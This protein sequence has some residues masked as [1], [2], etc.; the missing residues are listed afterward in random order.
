[1]ININFHFFLNHAIPN[2]KLKEIT[3][4]YPNL[5]QVNLTN[6]DFIKDSAL[7]HIARKST[8]LEYLNLNRCKNIS[9]KGIVSIIRNCRQ[10]KYLTLIFLPRIC[11]YKQMNVLLQ[12]L[13]IYSQLLESLHISN[14][15]ITNNNVTE[16]VKKCSKIN[17]LCFENAWGM[18]NSIFLGLISDNGLIE[19]S[20]HLTQNLTHLQV[21]YMN[22]SDKGLTE[23]A[24]YCTNITFLDISGN[25]DITDVG[26]IEV[27]TYCTQLVWLA[28]EQCGDIADRSVLLLAKKCQDLEHLSIGSIMTSIT[29]KGLITLMESCKKLT[30]LDVADCRCVSGPLKK[31]VFETYQN[32]MRQT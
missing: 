4:F 16:L 19:I 6:C 21:D 17:E 32:K 25:A 28:V 13:S 14:V 5:I 15:G 22:I 10:L 11:S 3:I 30:F 26:L 24:K 8:D 18:I 2:K 31:Q 1:M 7:T 29:D 27:A 20:R 9:I 12:Q 23:L